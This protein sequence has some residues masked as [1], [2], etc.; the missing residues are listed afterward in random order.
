MAISKIAHA[1]IK[2]TGSAALGKTSAAGI[3]MSGAPAKAIVRAIVTVTKMPQ[4]VA[5]VMAHVMAVGIM[6]G[7]HVTTTIMAT[8]HVALIHPIA[9]IA[10]IASK[11][12]AVLASIQASSMSNLRLSL[13][14]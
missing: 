3:T 13:K 12:H 9:T 5:G 1:T 11:A 6:I 14:P 8:A 10:I 7:L 2:V 4:I